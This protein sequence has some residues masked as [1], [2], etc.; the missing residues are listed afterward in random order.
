MKCEWQDCNQIFLNENSFIIHLEFHTFK[1]LK[2]K[3][4]NC[5][6]DVSNKEKQKYLLKQ[7]MTS[8]HNIKQFKCH[9]CSVFFKRKHSLDRHIFTKSCNIKI[10]YY[11]FPLLFKR[12]DPVKEICLEF[13]LKKYRPLK[14]KQK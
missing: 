1:K 4:G 9:I 13:Q 12:N 11:Q 10:N 14:L 5:D 2:C 7:H 3:W 8:H 6:Y